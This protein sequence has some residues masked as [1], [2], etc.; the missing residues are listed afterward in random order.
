MTEEV[1]QAQLSIQDIVAAVQVIDISAKRGTF[2]GT[3]LSQVGML[4]D[5]LAVFLKSQQPAEEE[6]A[7]AEEATE[8]TTEE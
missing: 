2:E 3:E 6:Q 8:E 5:R 4:R 7:A 1:Q